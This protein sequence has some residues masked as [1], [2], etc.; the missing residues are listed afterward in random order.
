[1]LDERQNA[2]VD[3]FDMSGVTVHA[4]HV[5]TG[6]GEADREREADTADADDGQSGYLIRFF[7]VHVSILLVEIS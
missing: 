6:F 2:C 4:D 5:Q 3:P 7:E 1:M